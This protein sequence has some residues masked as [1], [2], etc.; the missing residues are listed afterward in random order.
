MSIKDKAYARGMAEVFASNGFHRTA[1]CKV[2]EAIT[3]LT[4]KASLFNFSDSPYGGG[5]I[6][7]SSVL[8]PLLAAAGTGYV[9]YNAG[10]QGSKNRSA[11]SNIKNYIGRSLDKI[12][13][14]KRT[15]AMFN[16]NE[17]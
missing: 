3:G 6:S 4:K 9:A 10:I 17:F 11:Y 8:I 2:A 12:V 7:L 16:Y 15:P 1:A 14:P 13:R 5:G